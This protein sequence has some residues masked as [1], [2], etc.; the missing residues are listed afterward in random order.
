MKLAA[1]RS[2][3]QRTAAR[4]RRSAVSIRAAVARVRS[5]SAGTEPPRAAA[6][7]A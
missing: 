2:L 4:R 1:S 5:Y 7:A 3:W 6:F